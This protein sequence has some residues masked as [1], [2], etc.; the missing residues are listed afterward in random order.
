MY[1]NPLVNR[2]F[3]KKLILILIIY[4]LYL[5]IKSEDAES[6]SKALNE[7][8]NHIQYNEDYKEWKQYQ[9]RVEKIW[10]FIKLSVK[11]HFVNYI[12]NHSSPSEYYKW[13]IKHNSINTHVQ[14]QSLYE[15][16]NYISLEKD[17]IIQ[18]YIYKLNEINSRINTA[19][20]K[21]DINQIKLRILNNLSKSYQHFR[22]TYYLMN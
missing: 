18:Q 8:Y 3:I 19:G 20:S 12:S 4:D 1:F 13:L 6:I 2:R 22:T 17:Q 15:Q 7:R 9:S 16:F 21:F 14:L 5:E 11:S 10:D